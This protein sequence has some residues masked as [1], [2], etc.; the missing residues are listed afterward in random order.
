MD[1]KLIRPYFFAV[2]LIGVFVLT[3]YLLR[4]FLGALALAAIF[5]VVFTPLHDRITQ[6]V[7]GHRGIGASLTLLLIVVVLAVPLSLLGARFVSEAE[8]VFLWL[9]DPATLTYAQTSV[10]SAGVYAE[11]FVPGAQA[12]LQGLLGNLSSYSQ[13]A[14][15]WA[16]SNAAGLFSSAARFLLLTFVFFMALYYLLREAPSMRESV[17]RLSPLTPDETTSLL[18]RMSL[19]INSVVKGNLTVAFLQGFLVGIGFA[20]FGVPN[21]VLWGTLASAGALIPG[22]G[23]AIVIAPGIAYLFLTG[24]TGNAIGLLIWG[25]VIVG[26]VDT[27]L[28]PILIG[29]R[30]SI[31]PLLILLAVLGGL[32]MFGPAGIFLGPIIISFLLGLLSIYSP[33]AKDMPLESEELV[34]VEA[35]DAAA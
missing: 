33:A 5:A 1:H 35:T 23:T 11:Q 30:A 27:F 10:Q 14:I 19:T 29:G 34:I 2:L 4:P 31:H 3:Y 24:M 15:Q 16:L 20:L 18:H 22:V 6:V 9:T 21:A 12:Y 7:R 32:A 25:L 17:I 26:L 28:N 8:G 13:S